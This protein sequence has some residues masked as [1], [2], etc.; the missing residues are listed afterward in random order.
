MNSFSSEH[1]CLHSLLHVLCMV[2]ISHC[3][4]PGTFII[5]YQKSETL[6]FNSYLFKISLLAFGPCPIITP[7]LCT[8]KIIPDSA[9]GTTWD[10]W[11]QTG[12]T[13]CKCPTTYVVGA[14]LSVLSL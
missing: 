2:S 4:G 10:A 7:C 5:M 9:L 8:Q 11:D 3:M 1:T 13:T 6:F 12:L 14:L